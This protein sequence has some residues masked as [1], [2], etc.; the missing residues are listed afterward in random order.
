MRQAGIVAAAGLVA[1][2]TMVDR[3][4]DDHANARRL[5]EALAGLEGLRVDPEQVRT[6]MVIVEVH[7]PLNAAEFAARLRVGGVLVSP[8]GPRALRLVTHRHITRGAVERAAEV[9]RRAL[10]A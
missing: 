10:A 3:L 2:R 8:I 1:L 5:S 7:P 6:N 9:A 4:A